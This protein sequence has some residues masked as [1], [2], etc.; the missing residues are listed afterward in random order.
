MILKEFKLYKVT[1]RQNNVSGSVFIVAD[2]WPAVFNVMFERLPALEILA[3]Q[4]V[5]N[6]GTDFFID[7]EY[8]GTRSTEFDGDR[9]VIDGIPNY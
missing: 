6:E 2:S 1:Y 4:L 5:A 7:D 9:V 3:V 8:I